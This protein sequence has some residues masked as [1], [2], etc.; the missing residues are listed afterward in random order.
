VSRLVP[1]LVLASLAWVACVERALDPAPGGGQSDLSI[2]RYDGF[3][4]VDLARPVDLA[5]APDLRP[6]GGDCVEI[7]ACTQ[8]CDTDE[9]FFDCYDAASPAGQQAFVEYANCLDAECG[10]ICEFD[11]TPCDECID[12]VQSAPGTCG[13]GH[14]RCGRCRDEAAACG[15]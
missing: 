7:L 3:Q 10:T 4:I 11:T 15:L 5:R 13:P 6:P 14:P 2:S 8:D 9:C 1:C 12:D